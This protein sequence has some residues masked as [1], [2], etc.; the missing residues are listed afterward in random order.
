MIQVTI[1]KVDRYGYNG[2]DFHPQVTD[3]GAKGILIAA[4]VEQIAT[5]D[6]D[7]SMHTFSDG[8]TDVDLPRWKQ[9]N[10]DLI[11]GK[12]DEYP[13]MTILM[14]KLADGRRVDLVEHE[15]A[16]MEVIE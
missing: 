9:Q 12:G 5:D 2:R 14:V 8:V 13:P 11:S 1:G 7:P 6:Y 3:E 16:K 10:E 15:I 4:T